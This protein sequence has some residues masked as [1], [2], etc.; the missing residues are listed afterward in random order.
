MS[1]MLF[2]GRDHSAYP[3]PYV[4]CDAMMGTQELAGISAE[5]IMQLGVA[6][7][8]SK[9]LL[10]AVELDLFTELAVGPLDGETLQHRL[11]LHPR[12][13][14]DFFDALVALGLLGRQ[15]G[16]Y[17]TRRPLSSISTATRPVI[18][19]G[20]STWPTHSTIR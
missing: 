12:G 14:R 10:S 13:A 17:S 1:T 19:A 7:W 15:A 9:A 16:V 4:E 8:A 6:F 20:G 3:L 5:D 2:D 18:S 11:G